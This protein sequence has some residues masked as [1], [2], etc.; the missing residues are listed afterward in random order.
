MSDNQR[1]YVEYSQEIADEICLK[2]AT[3]SMGIASLCK[4]HYPNWPN[5]Q[6]IMEYYYEKE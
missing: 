1:K 5:K 4:L 6:T 3:T 2:T